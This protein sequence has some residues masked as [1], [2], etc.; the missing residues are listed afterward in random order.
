MTA[1]NPSVVLYD[2]RSEQIALVTLNMNTRSTVIYRVQELLCDGC[3]L[4]QAER[5][6]DSM[7]PIRLGVPVAGTRKF[8]AIG[9]NFADHAIEV[10]LP[11]PAEPIVFLKALSF[12]VLTMRSCCRRV[13][14]KAIGRWSSEW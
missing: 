9:T 8:I 10:K 14:S 7:R 3:P 12:P 1:A 11:I 6:Y 2:R 4:E 13:R 5:L